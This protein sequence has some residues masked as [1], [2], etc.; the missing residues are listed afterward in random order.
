MIGAPAPDASETMATQ[1]LPIQFPACA[2]VSLTPASPDDGAL[3][4]AE[5]QELKALQAIKKTCELPSAMDKQRF[6]DLKAHY[7]DSTAVK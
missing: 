7:P 1:Q 6:K 5:K 2:E 4:K 3:S